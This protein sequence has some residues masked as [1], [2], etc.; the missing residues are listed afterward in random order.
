VLSGFG[1]VEEIKLEPEGWRGWVW[2]GQS[3]PRLQRHPTTAVRGGSLL[4]FPRPRSCDR[5][6]L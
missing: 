4:E 2:Q 6:A 3:L 5:G 1:E